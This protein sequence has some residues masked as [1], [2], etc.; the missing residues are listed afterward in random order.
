M[1]QAS[2]RMEKALQ[3]LNGLEEGVARLEG[4]GRSSGQ[5]EDTE[6]PSGDYKKL[7]ADL[8]DIRR[9]IKNYLIADLNRPLLEQVLMR[10]DKLSASAG[11]DS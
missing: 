4:L 1:E 9:L 3:A 7:Q 11:K 2:A 8:E 10:V 5:V 6:K